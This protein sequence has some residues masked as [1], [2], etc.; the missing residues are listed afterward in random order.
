MNAVVAIVGG[1]SGFVA[2]YIALLA[3]VYF[4]FRR[5]RVVRCPTTRELIVVDVDSVHVL[6]TAV[7][8]SPQVR[9]GA[10][11]HWPEHSDCDQSCL[12]QLDTAAPVSPLGPRGS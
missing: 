1:L 12:R 2:V 4:W 3:A 7:L 9:V 6:R 5:P 10:C 8:G 11:S